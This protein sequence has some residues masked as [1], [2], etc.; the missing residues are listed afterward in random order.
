[1]SHCSIIQIILYVNVTNS[2]SFGGS[3]VFK[4]S[5][6]ILLLFFFSQVLFSQEKLYTINN[7]I[8]LDSVSILHKNLGLHINNLPLTT[9]SLAELKQ[10]YLPQ[11]NINAFMGDDQYVNIDKDPI[12]INKKYM[13]RILQ[14]SIHREDYTISTIRRFLGVSQNVLTFILFVIHLLKY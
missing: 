10:F 3:A 6:K 7:L 2:R 8:P 5:T 13:M 14:L 12:N 1:M 9:N 4:L 11:I